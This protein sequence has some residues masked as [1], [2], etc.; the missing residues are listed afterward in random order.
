[1][2]FIVKVSC[3]DSVDMRNILD[4]SFLM[5]CIGGFAGREW[6]SRLILIIQTPQTSSQTAGITVDDCDGRRASASTM[7]AGQHCGE[8]SDGE[9]DDKTHPTGTHLDPHS[10]P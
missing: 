1:M 8:D 5:D 3:S 6:Y 2:T 10:R 4:S 7:C 9:V